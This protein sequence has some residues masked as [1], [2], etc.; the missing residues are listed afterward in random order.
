MKLHW[1]CGDIYLDDYVNI[2]IHGV[3]EYT[4][5][6]NPNKTTLD[7]YYKRPFEKEFDKRERG[8]F[9]VDKILNILDIWPFAS[10]S[11]DEVVMISS[12]EH[13]FKPEMLFIKSQIERVLKS[14]GKFIVDFPD[15]KKDMELY[16]DS[17]PDYLMELIYCNGKNKHSIHKYGYT[18][19]SFKKLWGSKYNVEQ[20][21]IVEHNYPMI[22]MEVT[23]L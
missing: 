5:T 19:E 17:D 10:N 2:D 13:F 16:Y 22:G 8:M 9:I 20:K 14:G 12:W 15:I 1:C 18:V 6:E 11:I 7:S 4:L 23:K 3:L 21:I